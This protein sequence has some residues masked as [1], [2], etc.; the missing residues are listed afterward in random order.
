MYENIDYNYIV[1]MIKQDK[2]NENDLIKIVSLIY[3]RMEKIRD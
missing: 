1:D 2:M 3:I